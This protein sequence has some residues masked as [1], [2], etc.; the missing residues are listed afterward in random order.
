MKLRVILEIEINPKHYCHYI[1]P[2]GEWSEFDAASQFLHDEIQ[3]D[4]LQYSDYTFVGI[5]LPDIL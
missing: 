2:D 3:D 1:S 4:G 5:T